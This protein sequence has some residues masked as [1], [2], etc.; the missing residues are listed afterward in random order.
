M[1]D[2]RSK[3]R[4]SFPNLLYVFCFLVIIFESLGL[5]LVHSLDAEQLVCAVLDDRMLTDVGL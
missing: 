3:V 5:D 2:V 1:V 4:S